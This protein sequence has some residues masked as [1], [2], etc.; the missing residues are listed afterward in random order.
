MAQIKITL[1]KSTIGQM[2]NQKATIA[3]MGL[4]KIGNYIIREDD[5]IIRG[6]ID[7]VSHLV[8]V[9]EVK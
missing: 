9:E 6:M 2:E 3:A 8:K 5:P 4:R 1:T 7:K